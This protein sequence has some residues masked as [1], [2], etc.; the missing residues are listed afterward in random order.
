MPALARWVQVSAS[1]ER[2]R[3]RGF[4]PRQPPSEFQ[5]A[6]A[7]PFQHSSASTHQRGI[8]GYLNSPLVD[9]SGFSALFPPVYGKIKRADAV[10]IAG[11]L[12]RLRMAQRAHC[13][14]IAGAPMLLH[15]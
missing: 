9:S 2:A 6:S 11:P 14:L 13:V 10:L 7:F 15:G 5:V 12:Q 3:G 8:R 1:R 4:E